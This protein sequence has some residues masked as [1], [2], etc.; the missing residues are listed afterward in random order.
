MTLMSIF[1]VV[2]GLSSLKGSG[3]L[4]VSHPTRWTFSVG[5]SSRCWPLSEAVDICVKIFMRRGEV[6]EVEL[7]WERAVVLFEQSVL[8]K[9]VV[10][11][12]TLS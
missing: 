5:P 6:S 9:G 7:Y 4:I 11:V 8:E 1:R 3:A 2:L 10:S 12:S